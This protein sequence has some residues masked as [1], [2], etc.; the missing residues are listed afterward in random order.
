MELQDRGIHCVLSCL[1]LPAIVVFI[2]TKLVLEAQAGG[3]LCSFLSYL[4]PFHTSLIWD[5]GGTISN[6]KTELWFG[7]IMETIN[8][9]CGVT[10]DYSS[11]FFFYSHS[12]SNLLTSEDLPAL[13]VPM[14]QQLK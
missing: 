4:L 2:P 14:L 13:Q 5:K 1:L 7:L 10:S 8:P 3:L 6:L 9:L 12:S 11:I